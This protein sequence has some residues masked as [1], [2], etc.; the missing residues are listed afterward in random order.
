MGATAPK[1]NSGGYRANGWELQ[2]NWN[3][4]IG[5]DFSYSVGLSLSDARTK[6]TSYE[7]AA[8]I[9]YGKNKIVEGKPINSIYVFKTNGYLQNEEEVTAYYGTINGTGTLAPTQNS[10]NQLRPGCVRKVDLDENGA[11]KILFTNSLN[12][13]RKIKPFIFCSQ[14]NSKLIVWIRVTIIIE[15]I[16]SNR[17]F[18]IQVNFSHLS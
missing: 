17:S 11:N 12:E 14:T 15:V 4:R 16:R 18:F 8:A 10:N 7:G 1:T 2:L 13:C 9:T 6:V 3:D 5:R